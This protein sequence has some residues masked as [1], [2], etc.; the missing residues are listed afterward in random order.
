MRDKGAV[1]L[2]DV[3]QD[4]AKKKKKSSEFSDDEEDADAAFEKMKVGQRGDFFWIAEK[5]R[6]R[7]RL[8]RR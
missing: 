3:A 5:R 4:L 6:T 8:L 7:M 1:P 2:S